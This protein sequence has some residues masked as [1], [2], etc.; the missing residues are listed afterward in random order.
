MPIN[1]LVP[2]VGDAGLD[3][4]RHLS[5]NPDRWMLG[6]PRNDDGAP[7]GPKAVVRLNLRSERDVESHI[8]QPLFRDTLGYAQADLRWNYP[9]KI[10]S[11]RKKEGD[12]RDYRDL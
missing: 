10:T 1:W 7:S 6:V 9:V 8:V 12:A 3:D 5:D 2:Q 11:G 4:S